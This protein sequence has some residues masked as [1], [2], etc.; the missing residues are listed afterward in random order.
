METKERQDLLEHANFFTDITS[1]T[2]SADK[3]LILGTT[4][5]SQFTD[6]EE[7]KKVDYLKP[8]FR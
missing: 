6:L 7:K 1:V 2:K 5:L 8:T 3:N 4:N